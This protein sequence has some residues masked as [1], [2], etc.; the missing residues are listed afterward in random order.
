MHIHLCQWKLLKLPT[1]SKA[2]G[3]RQLWFLRGKWKIMESLSLNRISLTFLVVIKP[4]LWHNW[5]STLKSITL[6]NVRYYSFWNLHS[7]KWNLRLMFYD[8]EITSWKLALKP[9][10]SPS[11]VL[12]SNWFN[13][14]LNFSQCGLSCLET[15]HMQTQEQVVRSSPTLPILPSF[16]VCFCSEMDLTQCLICSGCLVD[17]SQYH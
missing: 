8:D 13:Y 1:P 15:S 3:F 2:P 5:E 9:S 17:I 12:L 14:L 6:C 11:A 10:F 7:W 16:S 4:P